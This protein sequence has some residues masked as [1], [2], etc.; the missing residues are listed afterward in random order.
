MGWGVGPVSTITERSDTTNTSTRAHREVESTMTDLDAM[1][2][3]LDA[4]N[5][6][7]AP[8]PKPGADELAAVAVAFRVAERSGIAVESPE[9]WDALARLRDAADRLLD[10]AS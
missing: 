8:P 7:L 9:W 6:A 5:R 1:A 3:A 10:G 2:V 4:T